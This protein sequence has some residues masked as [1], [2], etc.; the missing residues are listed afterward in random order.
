MV[1]DSDTICSF[2]SAG[3]GFVQERSNEATGSEEGRLERVTI[4]GM[5]IDR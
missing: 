4:P 3:E 5:D 2:E 1:T